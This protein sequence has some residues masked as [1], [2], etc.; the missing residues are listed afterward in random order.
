LKY[1]YVLSNKILAQ[2]HL[3]NAPNPVNA[4]TKI[5]YE[6]PSDGHVSLQVFDMTG[7]PVAVLV[8]SNM[9]AGNYSVNYNTSSLQS[10]IYNY[11]LTVSANN[12]VWVETKKFI[13]IK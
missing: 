12:K 11:R 10:G 9:K 4:A 6:L 13:V 1:D 7:K 8:N 2:F 5:Y 3:F